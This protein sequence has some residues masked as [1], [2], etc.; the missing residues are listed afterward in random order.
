MREMKMGLLNY[1][2]KIDVVKTTSEIMVVLQKHGASS[3]VFDYGGDGGL[4]AISFSVETPAGELAF[5]LPAD[6]QATQ[7]VLSKT[8]GQNTLYAK[9]AQAKRV[10]WR[11]ILLWIKAQMAFIETGM[12]RTEQVFLPYMVAKDGRTLYEV[13]VDQKFLL[14]K[15]G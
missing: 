3:I 7:R 13:L 1:S 6:W 11:N 15:E 10:A 4:S 9:E 8:Y 14:L 12:V 5:R 2:T